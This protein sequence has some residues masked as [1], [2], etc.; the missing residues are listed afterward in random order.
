MNKQQIIKRLYND[1]DYY[2]KFGQQYLS[3]SDISTLLKNPLSLHE[4]K[5]KSPAFVVGGYFHTCILEPDK[6]ESFKVIKNLLK[7]SLETSF[8]FKLLNLS[9]ISLY[10]LFKILL[11][12]FFI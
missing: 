10:L 12:Q 9:F 2:G 7:L 5:K 4:P 8:S 6:L 11:S 3:N 1:E